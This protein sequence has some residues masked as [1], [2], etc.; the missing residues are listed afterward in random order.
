[1]HQLAL[2]GRYF[3][4]GNHPLASGERRVLE[5]V[6]DRLG[7]PITVFDVGAN[8]GLYAH[9]V[10]DVLGEGVDLWCF[11][12]SASAF[13]QLRDSFSG[14]RG[15]KTRN[16]GFSDDS[17]KATLYSPA[18]AS[19]LSSVHDLSERFQR[20]ANAETREETIELTTIDAFCAQESIERIGLLKLDVEGHE[21][22]ALRGGQR[23]LASHAVDIIQFEFSAANIYSRV[24]LRDFFQLLVPDF[25]LY[26]VLR[27]SLQP[28]PVYRESDEVF[29][30]A[31]N[32]VAIARA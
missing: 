15:V 21:L 18:P 7:Q 3:G 32:Y 23:L 5:F 2:A 20:T 9:S 17:R 30:R 11:E 27:T 26:R 31:T 1:M 25:D 8:V 29:K 24:F 19:K 28:V 12:P 6:R 13:T 22:P 14:L 16:L 10:L 4:E